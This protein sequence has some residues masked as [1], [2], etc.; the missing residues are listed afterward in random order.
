MAR[1]CWSL[2]SLACVLLL[3][4]PPSSAEDT[5]CQSTGV[6]FANGGSYLIDVT[7]HGNFSFISQFSGMTALRHPP[8]RTPYAR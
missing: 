3:S 1:L 8:S 2:A 6:G 5:Q 4:A 7:S